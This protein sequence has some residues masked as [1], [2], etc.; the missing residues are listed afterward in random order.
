M[1]RF[2]LS[3][4]GPGYTSVWHRAPDGS[5][6]FWSTTAPELSCA[7]YAGA[8]SRESGR[9]DLRIDWPQPGR[10][11]I[12]SDDLDLRW[13]VE[14]GATPVGSVLGAVARR[15]PRRFLDREG[16]LS[17]L[18]PAAGALL[19]AGPFAL[20]GR[21]PNGQTFRLVPEYVWQVADGHARLRGVDLGP[22][23]PL[24]RQAALGGFRI[25][26]RGLLATGAISFDALDPERH[27]TRIVRA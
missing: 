20:T 3:S 26:Q 2:P 24:P 6:D 27:S 12:T 8:I 15:L 11:V 13:D 10:L 4:I 16:V 22:P 25:P 9:S 14:V 23:G 1:R 17:R 18:G 7:R 19:H 21:M 5:W